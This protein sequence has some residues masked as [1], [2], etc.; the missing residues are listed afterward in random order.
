MSAN[1]LKLSFF[2]VHRRNLR[3][4]RL[5]SQVWS[6]DV[7]SIMFSFF[8]VAIM[9][10]AVFIQATLFRAV[11]QPTSPLFVPARITS[12]AA[13]GAM[14]ET[15]ALSGVAC[16]AC[17]S[18]RAD[19][20]RH[21]S[22]RPTPMSIS[23]VSAAVAFISISQQRPLEIKSLFDKAIQDRRRVSKA[24]ATVPQD[25]DLKTQ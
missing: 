13:Q 15:R 10:V 5:H 12:P 25:E 22:P 20:M 19:P 6:P 3:T 9:L 11:G 23:P 24:E 21:E 7:M 14:R 1:D 2:C 16:A 18:Q 4:P 8:F 17:V